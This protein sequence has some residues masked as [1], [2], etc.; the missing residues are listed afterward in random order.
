[1]L[2]RSGE[3]LLLFA[4]PRNGVGATRISVR[5]GDSMGNPVD[6]VDGNEWLIRDGSW[7]FAYRGDRY[8][9]FSTR[10]DSLAILRIV[11]RNKIAVEHL[12]T[13]IRGRRVEV[14]QDWIQVD[15]VRFVDRVVSGQLIGLD[16]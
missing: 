13:T 1:M 15:S 12:R 2:F 11:M 10:N 9:F 5:L 4:P 8:C 6:I 3:L 7:A 14:T 16:L